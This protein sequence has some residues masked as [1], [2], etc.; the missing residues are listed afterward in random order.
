MS[1]KEANE[2]VLFEE[3]GGS[4]Y[5]V[6]FQT[7]VIGSA[8]GS[9]YENKTMDL[10]CQGRPISGIKFASFG[11]VQGTCGS[12][13]KGTCQGPNDAVSIISKVY[14]TSFIVYICILF[15]CYILELELIVL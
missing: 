13:E 1:D 15:V 3:M 4:P 14:M 8:C 11:D 9:A 6:N 12:F 10:S 7:N 5:L 2:L